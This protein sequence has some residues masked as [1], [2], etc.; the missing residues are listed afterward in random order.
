[1]YNTQSVNILIIFHSADVINGCNKDKV[2]DTPESSVELAMVLFFV[3]NDYD[4][5][6]TS[7][8]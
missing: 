5:R 4:A 3:E 6:G 8:C 2:V 1:M 7:K